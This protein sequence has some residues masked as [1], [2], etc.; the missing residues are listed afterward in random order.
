MTT[1]LKIALI[2]PFIGFCAPAVNADPVHTYTA[3]ERA[4]GLDAPTQ[5]LLAWAQAIGDK[6]I[7]AMGKLVMDKANDFTVFEGSGVNTGWADYR[8]NHLAP[9]FANPDL[10]FQTYAFDN[11]STSQDGDLA[12]SI[13]SIKMVYTYKGEKKSRTGR[14]TAVMVRDGDTW[15]LVHLHTS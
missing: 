15:K 6:D 2:A 13:F 12:Y 4:A 3:Q 11:I 9:E 10:V 5:V 8:D 1:L 14:G 7:A